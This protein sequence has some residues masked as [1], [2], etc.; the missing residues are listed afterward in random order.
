MN[1]NAFNFAPI[2]SRLC[3]IFFRH[4]PYVFLRVPTN[5]GTRVTPFFSKNLLSL[6]TLNCCIFKLNVSVIHCDAP[7]QLQLH[8]SLSEV[9][10]DK[11]NFRMFRDCFDM[12]HHAWISIFYQMALIL[13]FPLFIL[14]AVKFDSFIQLRYR[15]HTSCPWLLF[16]T[17]QHSGM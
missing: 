17:K 2:F 4:L 16:V 14:D 9:M 3:A 10:A 8:L 11:P 15:T 13:H 7:S 1:F 6:K 12:H 5:L